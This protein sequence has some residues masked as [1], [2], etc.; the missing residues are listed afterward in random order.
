MAEASEDHTACDI[1][2]RMEEAFERWNLEAAS[3]SADNVRNISLAI[4][5]LV[6]SYKYN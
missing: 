2:T 4:E 6:C 3:L 1:A 5:Q